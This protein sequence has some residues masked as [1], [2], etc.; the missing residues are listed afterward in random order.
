[1]PRI[2]LVD[3]DARVRDALSLGL[4]DAGYEVVLAAGGEAALALLEREPVDAVITDTKMPGFDG[5]R[6]I[7]AL[8]ARHPELPIIAM[9]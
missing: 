3:D 1:M 7:T 8:R 9:T 5:G 4:G 2:C 6:L